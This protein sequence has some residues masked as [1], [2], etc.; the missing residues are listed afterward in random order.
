MNKENYETIDNNTT[1]HTQ[2]TESCSQKIYLLIY[3]ILCI[4][5]LV[6]FL[7]SEDFFEEQTTELMAIQVNSLY[8]KKGN[9]GLY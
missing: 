5:E 3:L 2:L 9:H 4:P 6:E 8:N 1:E 7:H